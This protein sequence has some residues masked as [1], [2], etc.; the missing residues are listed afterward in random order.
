MHETHS[1]TCRIDYDAFR[2]WTLEMRVNFARLL[3]SVKSAKMAEYKK[4]K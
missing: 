4:L 1:A 3:I 2:N